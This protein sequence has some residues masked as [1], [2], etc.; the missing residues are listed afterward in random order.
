M[1]SKKYD[2]IVVG[3]GATGGIAAKEL[4]EKG[5]E[6]LVLE[7]GPPLQESLFH[8]K[9]PGFKGIGSATRI[10]A[11]LRGQYKQARHSFFSE[12]KSFLFVND[13]EHPY[14]SSEDFFL[15]M[16]GKHV[17]GRFLSW[18]RVALRMSDYAFKAHSHEGAGFD[19]PIS[20]SDL[21]PYYDQIETFLGIVGKNEGVPFMPDG[22]Y[23]KEAGLSTAE[24][25]FKNQVESKWPDRKVIAWRY[26]QKEATPVDEEG[27]RTSSPLAAA[28]KTGQLTLRPNSLV[29]IVITDP[30]T[31]K[32]TGVTFVDALSKE[33][34]TVHAKAVMLCAST[35]ETI[36][37]LLNSK[38][39]K[40][41]EG[42]GNASGLV[43][44]YFMDQV[45]S[46]VFGTV[47]GR[48]GGELVDGEHFGDNHGGIYIPRFQNLDNVTHPEY[49]GGFN[50]QGV[51]G[52]MPAPGNS[53]FGMMGHGEM[54]P[55]KENQ[56]RLSKRKDK[57][58]IPIPDIKLKLQQNEINLVK[59]QLA[60]QRELF[61]EVGYNIDFA[62]NILELQ[63][64]YKLLPHA[65]VIE[66]MLFKM[67]WRKSMAVGAAIHE[68][69][70][71]KMGFDP[72]D[73]VL[74]SRNQIWD[75]PNVFITD[76]TCFPT[77]GSCGPTLTTMALTA[78]ACDFIAEEIDNL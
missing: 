9:G 50:L 5:L 63:K 41:P 23:V 46:I 78:R 2:V 15:F 45:P 66:R 3:S 29:S 76:S 73:S 40:H 51:I 10:K 53:V 32:A 61:R 64:D 21:E 31:G 62:M 13:N 28:K 7:A 34:H 60:T 65:G 36:R 6:V 20:Y 37:L 54:L 44:K 71:A 52:R 55:Y 67:N 77:N 26:V 58:G 14:T 47:P 33:T 30:Q 48:E 38:S 68:C 16:R 57:W 74:N 59:S 49:K 18:G 17:G 43:G 11:A 42:L 72:S 12:E 39:T 1:N 25:D 24:T 19:W 27:H 75:A 35:I 56:V 22:K 69:G 4:T 8:Q 70:G